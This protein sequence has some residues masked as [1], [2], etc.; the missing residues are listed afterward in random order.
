MTIHASEVLVRRY[1]EQALSHADWDT[2]NAIVAPNHVDHEEVPHIPPTR[3]GL[4]HKYELLRGG[5]PDLRFVVEE[6]VGSGDRV[7]ARVTVHGTHTQPFL[8]RAPTGRQ[9][10][11]SKFSIF[12]IAEGRIVEH[13]GLFDQMAMM[14]Q[15]GPFPSGG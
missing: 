6:T 10:A 3:E 15:L 2:L 7:A 1:Y 11:A 5:C 4:K 13:W 9:M 8:G 12:R 14:V